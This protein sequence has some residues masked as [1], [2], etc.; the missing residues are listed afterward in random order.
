MAECGIKSTNGLSNFN[1]ENPV[2]VILGRNW[3]VERE[4]PSRR[5]VAFRKLMPLTGH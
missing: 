1:P 2:K 3:K 5:S 4:E